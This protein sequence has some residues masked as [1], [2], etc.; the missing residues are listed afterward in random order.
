MYLSMLSIQNNYKKTITNAGKIFQLGLSK[1]KKNYNKLQTGFSIIELL[2]AM[3]IIAILF[4]SSYSFNISKNIYYKHKA[5]NFYH[6]FNH[7]INQAKTIAGLTNENIILCPIDQ[8]HIKLKK[9]HKQYCSTNWHNPI[10]VFYDSHQKNLL[11]TTLIFVHQELIHQN[12]KLRLNCFKRNN[13]I[14][15]NKNFENNSL[16]CSVYYNNLYYSKKIF[17]NKSGRI[18]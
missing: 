18:R 1:N 17:L 9:I 4:A 6:K 5:N 16:N 2:I 8:A 3:L 15:F 7:I 11:N 12:E 10:A 13:Y 14:K